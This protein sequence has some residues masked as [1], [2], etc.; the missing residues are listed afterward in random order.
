MCVFQALAIIF[1]SEEGKF[2]CCNFYY[3]ITSFLLIFILY[4][5]LVF[6]IVIPFYS[7]YIFIVI[8]TGA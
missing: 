4:F 2:V 6:L 8:L 5:I 1:R 3:F 7:M